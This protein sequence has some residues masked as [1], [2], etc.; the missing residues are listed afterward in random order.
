MNSKDYAKAR[1]LWNKGIPTKIIAHEI[2]IE[3]YV[4]IGY[5]ARYRNDFPARRKCKRLTDQQRKDIIDLKKNGVPNKEISERIG[6]SK[7]TVLYVLKA[8]KL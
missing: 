7:R 1:D 4:L 6:C 2:G 3:T 5:A 8:S